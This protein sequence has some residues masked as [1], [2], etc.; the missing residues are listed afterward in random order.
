MIKGL[1]KVNYGIFRDILAVVS[2]T[3]NLMHGQVLVVG[4][5][6]F[7]SVKQA[8]AHDLL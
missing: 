7:S 5:F 3:V 8:C 4:V 6:T 1:V 2:L